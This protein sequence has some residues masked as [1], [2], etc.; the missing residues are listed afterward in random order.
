ME[1]QVGRMAQVFFTGHQGS[2]GL[3]E[4]SGGQTDFFFLFELDHK[5]CFPSCFSHGLAGKPRSKEG[6][7]LRLMNCLCTKRFT[8]LILSMGLRWWLRW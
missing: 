1:G 6:R 7:E 8:L 5:A 2:R 3:G 4:G